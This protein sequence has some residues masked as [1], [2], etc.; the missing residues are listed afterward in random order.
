MS[1]WR[2]LFVASAD[3][4]QGVSSS[5]C[6]TFPAWSCP[7]VQ[8][9]G[10]REAVILRQNGHNCRACRDDALQ[11]VMH[12]KGVL[13][14]T[15]GMLQ[16]NTASLA[17]PPSRAWRACRTSPDADESFQ[18]DVIFFDEVSQRASSSAQDMSSEGALYEIWNNDRTDGQCPGTVSQQPL[19]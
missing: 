5:S 14:T 10:L 19:R 7:C 17:A 4:E 18:W 16:H 3:F 15:Y 9:C 11:R 2:C 12:G 1:A 13:L 6:Q 8:T